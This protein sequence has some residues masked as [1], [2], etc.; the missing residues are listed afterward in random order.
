MPNVFCIFERYAGDVMWRHTETAIP[1][2]V[3]EV[4]PEISL[5]V[6]MVSTV[7]NYDYIIDWE[8]TQSGSIRFKVGLTGL[9]EV[10]GS[11]YT[12]TDQISDEEYGILLAENTIGSRHDHFLTYHLD[13]DIDGEANS[14]VKSTL[15]M[16]KADGHPRSSHWKV[17]SEMAKTESDA[18]IRLGIDQA[19]FLF[20]N[21]NKRTR[22]GNLVGYRLI[23]GSVVGPLL[24][25]DDYAQIRGAFT[26]YNV[27][28]T[29]YNKYEKWAVGPLADQ[30]RGD[31]TLA[32]WSQ[33]NREIENR[34]I[35]LWYSVGFH[36]I[37]YQ[38][39]FPV[40]PTLHGGFELR[41]SNF[42]ERNP[43]LH[44]N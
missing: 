15:Q 38:E 29:P 9:L 18:K 30:S 40:M 44:Q 16:S 19:E 23:P 32:T 13:L 43:L 42:F 6:R 21:P 34:D 1:G 27:W 41:P 4:R 36:H 5:V 7:G 3:V 17:V 20:V 24:S 39:D 37:P 10:R 8:F 35:V 2:K 26:K 12:H 33:R 31:D 14:F 28:V 22:M 25:D 11:K